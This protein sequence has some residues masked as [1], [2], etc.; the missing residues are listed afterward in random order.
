MAT[1]WTKQA[2]IDSAA[3]YKTVRAWREAEPSAYSTA[4][5]KKLLPELTKNMSR[6]RVPQGS[7]T[8]SRVIAS[9]LKFKTKTEWLMAVPTAYHKS[10]KYNWHN[11]ATAHMHAMGNKYSRLVYAIKIKKYNLIYV[12][13]TGNPKRR[14]RDHLKTKRFKSLIKKVGQENIEFELLTDFL[15]VDKAASME[16]K[17]INKF[18]LDGYELLNKA[19]AGGL[20]GITIK[21]T[22]EAILR[23][24]R[25]YE[26][27]ME[28][29]KAPGGAY[30]QASTRGLLK[31]ATSHLKRQMRTP[32]T[33]TFAEVIERSKVFD[34][35]SAWRK[36]DPSSYNAAKRYGWYKQPEVS[37]HMERRVYLDKK[38]T[39]E[40]IFADAKNYKTRGAWF[41]VSPGA[42]GGA[43]KMGVYK[44]A[45]AHMERSKVEKKW[46]KKAVIESA[47]KYPNKPEWREA[48]SGAY[49]TAQKKGW[50]KEASAHMEILNPIGKWASEE[51]VV[52]EARRYETKSE[53][54]R[55][56]SGSYEAAKRLGCFNEAIEHMRLVRQSWTKEKVIASARN[57][58]TIAGWRQKNSPAYAAARRLKIVKQATAHMM[59]LNP[60][61]AWLTKEAVVSDAK[62]YTSRT[63]WYKGS[64]GAYAS[65]KRNGWFEEAVKHM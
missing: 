45:I 38:W 48:E 22:D 2:L 52:K 29:V 40:R 16:A 24:A 27:V 54:Q 5:Q 55:V 25:K 21:W 35:T 60:I 4:A 65:A 53:W 6:E 37:G 34:S 62:K 51:T 31:K 50:M 57:F 58:K 56:S 46:T 59:I 13:L 30:T 33:W 23:D 61:G 64:G 15:S 3:P 49:S 41:T 26:S 36:Q 8:K 63:S 10:V 42:V 28:W 39:K 11:E 32:G 12:G 1:K 9:A 20:G 19:K 44:Y 47:Q 17:F 43:K 18:S 14:F 7:W